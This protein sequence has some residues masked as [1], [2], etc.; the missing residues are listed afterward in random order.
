LELRKYHAAL[1]GS[2]SAGGVDLV[3]H[4]GSPGDQPIVGDWDGNRTST[5]GVF[6]P[7]NAAFYLSNTF[8]GALGT[9]FYFGV[10]NDVAIT[11]DWNADGYWTVGVYRNGIRYLSNSNLN[12]TTDVVFTY[13]ANHN[14]HLVWR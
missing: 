12:P 14:R 5:P 6:R 9:W 13:G 2:N 10:P 7:S 1:L 8:N 4:F 3:F 11:G